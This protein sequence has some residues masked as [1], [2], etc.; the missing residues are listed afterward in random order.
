VLGPLR[1]RLTHAADV[2]RGLGLRRSLTLLPAWLVLRREFVAVAW[3]IPVR[4]RDLPDLSGMRCDVLGEAELPA[5][6]AGCP[7]L[8]AREVR[9]RWA[10]GLECLVLWRGHAVVAYRWDVT[11][12]A[13]AL[14]LPYL[15]TIVRLAPGDVLVYDART[16][17]A[18]RRLRLGA[19]LLAAAV[20]RAQARGARRYVGLIAAWNHASLR[21]ADYLGWERVGTVGYRRVGLRRR[22][23]ATG[24]MAIVGREVR[25]LPSAEP[26][27]PPV[28]VTAPSNAP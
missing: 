5:F 12:A 15:G 4:P 24:V 18:S 8:T 26:R 13:G 9:R 22:Y 14:H 17:P 11:A 1:A 25:F 19:E 10:A 27:D 7:E 23:V 28:R 2:F 3:P 20:A 6:A 16:L 21:W